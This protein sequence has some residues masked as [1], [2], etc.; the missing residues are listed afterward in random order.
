[1]KITQQSWQTKG[2]TMSKL[3]DYIYSDT[4][5]DIERFEAD[6]YCVIIKWDGESKIIE[7]FQRGYLESLYGGESL[8]AAQQSTGLTNDQ[9]DEL[10]SMDVQYMESR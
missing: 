4:Q 8:D 2:K 7:T 1:M 6:E 3:T 9:W 10:L 5:T